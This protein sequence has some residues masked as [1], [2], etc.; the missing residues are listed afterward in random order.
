MENE[1]VKKLTGK[2]PKDFEFAAAHIIS[3][4]DEDAFAALIEKSDFLFDFVKEN[5][6]KRLANVVT[7]YNYKNLLC[8]LKMHSYE[9]EDF[10]VPT[11]V[12]FADEELTDEMLNRLENGSKDE[13]TY[14]AKYFSYINDTL[15]ID[16]LRKYSYS[17]FD[18]LAFNCAEALSKMGDEFSYN[19]A[20]EKLNSPDEFE[21][22]SAAKFLSAYKDK[23]AVGVLLE[24]MKKSSMPENIAAE[25]PYLQSL[26]ELFDTDLKRDALLCFNYILEGLGEII[27]LSQ[28]F[29]LEVYEV[30]E[31]LIACQQFEN[32]PRIALVLLNAKQKFEQLTESDEYIF[33]ENKAVKEEIYAIKEF[34]SFANED[35]WPK[36]IEL[37]SEVLDEDNSFIFSALGL[38]QELNYCEAL[39][40]LKELLKT[41][42]QTLVLKTLEVIKSLDKLQSVDKKG[43]LERISDENIK[44]II[45]SL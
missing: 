23:R 26:L 4:C 42:N 16:L 37:F 15:A 22:L 7:N 21:K 18:E 35:L 3:N 1:Y 27:D 38:V 29:G 31:K 17:E 36:Q 34:L 33:D 14:A 11:L 24:T 20:I 32:S 40:K 19:S 8:F 30:I 45:Q 5:V 9:Y 28:V 12:K 2:I 44:L 10:I 39:G 6:K 41:S 43:I 13:K 25:I